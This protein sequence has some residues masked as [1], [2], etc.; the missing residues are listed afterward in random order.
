MR[1]TLCAMDRPANELGIC[2]AWQRCVRAAVLVAALATLL[3]ACGGSMQ[4]PC[5]RDSI[6]GSEQ[7]QPVGHNYG[8][9]AALGGTAAGTWAVLG[10]TVNGCTPPDYCNSKTKLCESPRCK[11]DHDCPAAYHCDSEHALCR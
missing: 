4:Y 10:C 8:Q 7:C 9:A 2:S 5:K 11:T 1:G 6:T 3:L